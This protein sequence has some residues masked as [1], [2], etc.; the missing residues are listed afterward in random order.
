MNPLSLL[1]TAI[2]TLWYWTYGIIVG[3]GASFTIILALFLILFL[4][5][6]RINRRMNYLNNRLVAFERDVSLTINE[7]NK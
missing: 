6:V 2:D 4:K 3:W 5:V 7:I 1:N